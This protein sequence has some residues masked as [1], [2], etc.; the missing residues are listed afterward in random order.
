VYHKDLA[1]DHLLDL[2]AKQ[3]LAACQAAW[4]FGG[5]GSWNDL[6][7]EGEQQ[8]EY[9]RISTALYDLLNTAI[10]AAASHMPQ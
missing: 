9:D 8:A 6:G 5:M 1:P 3:V 2:P 4:V 10:A 7:F